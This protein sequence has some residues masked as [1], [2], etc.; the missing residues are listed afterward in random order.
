M[1]RYLH[2]FLRYWP[3]V[4]LPVL[5]LP[6]A[7]YLMLGRTPRT[8]IAMTSVYANSSSE[9]SYIYYDQYSS[10][11]QNLA[12]DMSQLVQLSSFDERVVRQALQAGNKTYA[13]LLPDVS[14]IQ[15]TPI[16]TSVVSVSLTSPDPSLAR[17]VIKAFL[18]QA[19][20]E[21][22]K[23]NQKQNST[24][25]SQLNQAVHTDA[26][27]FRAASDSLRSY[28]SAHGIA[29]GDLLTSQQADPTLANLNQ[30]V[31]NDLQQLQRDKSQLSSTQLQ[32]QNL[33]N[34]GVLSFFQ[35]VDPIVAYPQSNKKTE[36]KNVAIAL[37]LGLLLG[38]AFLVTKTAMDAGIRFGEEVPELLGLPILVE[39][40]YS[41]AD[42][43]SA[44][45]KRTGRPTV[46][47][48]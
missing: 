23:L 10:P 29:P 13:M 14:A 7:T 8:Y 5:I 43:K 9:Q 34:S 44:R 48:A 28:M 17:A 35:N 26:L 15:A 31:I 6:A 11:A 33:Q 21:T 37:L 30:Q 16:G 12:S 19:S 18:L 32:Q 22:L 4:L 24:S 41:E 2:T 25:L 20:Q 45:R 3:V 39:I 47:V 40:P 27:Q 1:R 36:I 38:G 46:E 42:S